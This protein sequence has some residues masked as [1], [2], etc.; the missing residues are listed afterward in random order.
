MASTT[1]ANITKLTTGQV[2]KEATINAALDR[3]D[4]MLTGRLGIVTTGGTRTLTGTDAAPEAQVL[5]LDI[6]GALG[7]NAII[8]IPVT[9]RNGIYVVK[10]GTTGAFSVTVR[11]VSGSGVTITQTKTVILYYNGTD[12]A[13]ATAEI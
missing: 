8:Q 6:S 10:N 13:K 12:F 4:S 7:S 1:G 9:G 3:V 2:Q 5:F 11:K